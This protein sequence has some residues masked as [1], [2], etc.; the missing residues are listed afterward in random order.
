[1]GGRTLGIDATGANIAIA[2]EHAARDPSLSGKLSHLKYEHGTAEAVLARGQQFDV[3]TSME[4]VE[5]VAD[6]ES[7]VRTLAALVKPGGHIFMSTIAKTPLS[8]FLTIA[9]AE[10]VL[11]LAT[12]GT[13]HWSQYVDPEQLAS[14]FTEGLG[15]YKNAET[16]NPDLPRRLQLETRGIIYMPWKNTWDLAPRDCSLAKQC[17]YVFWIRKPLEVPSRQ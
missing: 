12:P 1:M 11:R 17:N 4:V 14:F 13:H 10:N 2:S 9:M 7:F 15:W 16:Q 5:H 6:P 3:V 8:W